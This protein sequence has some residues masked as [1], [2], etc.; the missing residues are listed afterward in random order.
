MFFITYQR[1][2]FQLIT[3][4]LNFVVYRVQHYINGKEYV[5]NTV[6]YVG[7]HKLCELWQYTRYQ[8]EGGRQIYDTAEIID[9]EQKIH[10]ELLEYSIGVLNALGIQYGPAHVEV[11]VSPKRFR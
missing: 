2:T 8:R 7:Q 10:K 1:V 4:F 3:Y 9:Y 11:L 5:V 6:S